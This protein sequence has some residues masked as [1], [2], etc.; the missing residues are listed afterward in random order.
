MNQAIIDSKKQIVAEISEKFQ[1]AQS[2]VVCVEAT[3]R[4][5][6]GLD[7]PTDAG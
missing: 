5:L 7:I 2:A 3:R 4:T 1:N 6:P